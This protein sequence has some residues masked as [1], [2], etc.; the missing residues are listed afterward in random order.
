MIQIEGTYYFSL[1]LSDSFEGMI[2]IPYRSFRIV[3][4]EQI[5]GAVTFSASEGKK[6]DSIS[7]YSPYSP[8]HSGGITT[9]HLWVDGIFD[10][11]WVEGEGVSEAEVPSYIFRPMQRSLFIRWSRIS[12]SMNL[13]RRETFRRLMPGSIR[14]F[15][16]MDAFTRQL[17]FS[18]AAAGKNL[19]R[20]TT[21]SI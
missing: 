3:S 19:I 10:E 13:W 15:I 21:W 12:R 5:T 9:G 16:S 11:F 18:D 7:W 2:R 8:S 17:S 20:G 6:Y 1:I 14:R 4:N